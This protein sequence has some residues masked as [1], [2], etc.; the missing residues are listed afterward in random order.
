MRAKGHGSPQLT[1][2]A[3]ARHEIWN[4]TSNRRSAYSFGLGPSTCTPDHFVKLQSETAL[5]PACAY[6]RD[7]RFSSSVLLYAL[8]DNARVTLLNFLF[9]FP[10]VR[11][12]SLLEIYRVRGSGV[13]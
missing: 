8:W 7:T 9:G 11:Q 10:S 3:T 2:Y 12:G 6:E 1:G 5:I 4:F 13:D